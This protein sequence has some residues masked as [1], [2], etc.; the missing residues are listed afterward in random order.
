VQRVVGRFIG[1][2]TRLNV[3]RG[4]DARRLDPQNTTV[5]PT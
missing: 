1:E 3:T 2:A 4:R 5:R